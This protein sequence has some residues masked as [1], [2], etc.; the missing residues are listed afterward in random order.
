LL[1]IMLRDKKHE[2]TMILVSWLYTPTAAMSGVCLSVCLSAS[3]HTEPPQG[4]IRLGQH[5]S[6]R[7]YDGRH[8]PASTRCLTTAT[9]NS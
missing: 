4:S 5:L 2:Q 3:T 8:I 7:L 9:T 6:V 1:L